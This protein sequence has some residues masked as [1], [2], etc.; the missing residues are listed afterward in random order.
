MRNLILKINVN[1]FVLIPSYDTCNHIIYFFQKDITVNKMD[2]FFYSP[3]PVC[4]DNVNRLSKRSYSYFSGSEFL[5]LSQILQAWV[6]FFLLKAESANK[7]MTLGGDRLC[8]NL[9]L[10]RLRFSTDLLGVPFQNSGWSLSSAP[11]TNQML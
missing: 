5:Y 3:N 1:M 7:E 2:A 8:R 4:K 9:Y 10:I 6:C 11:L